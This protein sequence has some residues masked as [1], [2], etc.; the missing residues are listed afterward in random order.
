MT[1]SKFNPLLFPRCFKSYPEQFLYSAWIEHVPF[2]FSLIEMVRP[3][4]FVELGTYGGASYC[5]FCESV[6]DL[7]LNTRC[8]AVDTWLGDEHAGYYGNDVYKS[9]KNF[10]DSRFANFSELVRTTFE[11][12]S[13]RFVNSSIDLLHIDGLH[14]YEAV[15]SDFE[16]WLPK[17]SKSGVILFHD[18]T[19]RQ[20][21]FGVW[22]F[23]D[24]IKN[25][26][27]SFEFLHGHGLGVL[28]VGDTIATPLEAL[29][30]ASVYEQQA[31]R[32]FYF[33]QGN[34]FTKDLM[35]LNCKNE[36]EEKQRN[37]DD[38]HL[39][40]EE[41]ELIIKNYENSRSWRITRP[42]RAVSA[43]LKK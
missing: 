36:I 19:V 37:I 4:T 23:W 18:T 10:H 39:R 34:H 15:K 22:R 26:Y 42:L 16:T 25:A 29:C 32:S 24:E 11:E 28:V 1:I 27:P 2:A 17:M 6:K 38:L 35:L 40:L 30:S 3:R 7:N 33:S 41:F 20:A 14:T 5:A 43:I 31:I 12:A 13:E 21:D 8:F 9:L